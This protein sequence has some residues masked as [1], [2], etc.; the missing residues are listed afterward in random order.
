MPDV[1]EV[2]REPAGDEFI[3]SLATAGSGDVLAANGI[4]NDAFYTDVR[5]VLAELRRRYEVSVAETGDQ[6]LHRRAELG[7]PDARGVT[8][9]TSL[10][11]R[12]NAAARRQ[13]VEHFAKPLP[14]A[15]PGRRVEYDEHAARRASSG[16]SVE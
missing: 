1:G 4:F 14:S 15:T 16:S 3:D 5:P 9:R 7:H 8:G 6:D 2:A 12:R 10:P 11:H 13:G